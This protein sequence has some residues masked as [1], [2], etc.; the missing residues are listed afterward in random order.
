MSRR[1]VKSF[2]LKRPNQFIPPNTTTF[3]F[4]GEPGETDYKLQV[5]PCRAFAGLLH[6][7]EAFQARCKR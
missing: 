6:R 1:R 2:A 4:N 5:R 7:R 3:L